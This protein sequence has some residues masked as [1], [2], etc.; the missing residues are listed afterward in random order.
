MLRISAGPWRKRWLSMTQSTHHGN[1][2]SCRIEN[3]NHAVQK[4]ARVGTRVKSTCQVSLGFSAWIGF[5][6]GFAL[7]GHLPEEE[8]EWIRG[9]IEQVLSS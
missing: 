6:F 9:V 5:A 8:K 3:G 1:S 4:P 2:Q 7:G